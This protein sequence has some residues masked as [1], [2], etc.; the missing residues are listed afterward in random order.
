MPNRDDAVA[1]DFLDIRDRVNRITNSSGLLSVAFHPE[2]RTNGLFYVCY[3]R[4]NFYS[5]VSEFRV[6][7]DPNVADVDSERVLLEVRQ[8]GSHHNSNHLAFGPDGMLAGQKV[9]ILVDGTR[10]VG[11]Y[12]ERWDGRDDSGRDLATGI[13]LYRLRTGTQTETRK[14]L[15]L[16]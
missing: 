14:L 15:L 3:G 1:T 10:Q 2:H 6:S 7:A 11:T 9:A 13:Y 5:R 4:G 8:T 16:R 12:T